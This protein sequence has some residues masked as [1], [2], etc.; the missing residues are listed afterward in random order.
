MGARRGGGTLSVDDNVGGDESRDE[1]DGRLHYDFLLET[2][3][4]GTP[5]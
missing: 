3:P 1:E 5:P 2:F 4:K